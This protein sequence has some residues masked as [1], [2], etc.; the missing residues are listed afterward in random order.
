M[1]SATQSRCT[2]P[3]LPRHPNSGSVVALAGETHGIKRN[4]M[5]AILRSKALE[6]GA[7]V[8]GRL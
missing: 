8:R 6:M 3:H 2:S 1:I 7:E 5:P 4:R